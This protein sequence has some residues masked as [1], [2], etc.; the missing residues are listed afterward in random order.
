L[1][2]VPQ[3][4]E[5]NDQRLADSSGV[6]RTDQLYDDIDIREFE[7]V[8]SEHLANDTLGPISIDCPA[9]YTLAD[10]ETQA[11]RVHCIG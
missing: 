8:T 9:Q 11:G 1:T 10:D 2:P 6:R 7:P 3:L 5:R 4:A